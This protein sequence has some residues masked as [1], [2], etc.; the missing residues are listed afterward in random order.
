[1]L[2]FN[3]EDG[4]TSSGVLRPYSR[5]EE[6]GISLGSTADRPE[7][8]FESLLRVIPFLVSRSTNSLK[9]T[10]ARD[11]SRWFDVLDWGGFYCR[12]NGIHEEV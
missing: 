12:I 7:I 10:R 11:I 1:M 3:G 6:E 8:C 9:L 5:K 4:W 2:N